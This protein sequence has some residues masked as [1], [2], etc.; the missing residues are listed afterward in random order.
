MAEAPDVQ[1]TERNRFRVKALGNAFTH[2]LLEWPE[3]SVDL[4]LI[5]FCI[6]GEEQSY[7]GLIRDDPSLLGLPRPFYLTVLNSLDCCFVK[8]EVRSCCVL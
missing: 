8:H 3:F 2:T 1:D 6:L 5:E 7:H 4:R